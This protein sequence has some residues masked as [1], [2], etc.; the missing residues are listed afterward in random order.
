M[1]LKY[2]KFFFNIVE[3]LLLSKNIIGLSPSEIKLS[4]DNDQS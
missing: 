2:I 3:M 4:G 1:V